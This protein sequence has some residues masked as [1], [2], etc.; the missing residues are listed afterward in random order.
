MTDIWDSIGYN[1]FFGISDE[2]YN[3][4]L[5]CPRDIVIYYTECACQLC[6]HD[7]L[8]QLCPYNLIEISR[9]GR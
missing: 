2:C 9:N 8:I 4:S 7:K 3:H 5:Q 1:Y 6:S